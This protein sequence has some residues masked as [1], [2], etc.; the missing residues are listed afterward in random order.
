MLTVSSLS[1]KTDIPC[2]RLRSIENKPQ[3]DALQEEALMKKVLMTGMLLMVM[4]WLMGCCFRGHR[5]SMVG[6]GRAAAIGSSHCRLHQGTFCV[7]TGPEKEV[8]TEELPASSAE[9]AL[10]GDR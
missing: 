7:Q 4:I 1:A 9:L 2:V 5:C 10:A 8:H 6:C 3:T